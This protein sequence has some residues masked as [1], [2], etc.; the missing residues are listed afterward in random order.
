MAASLNSYLTTIVASVVDNND[1]TASLRSNSSSKDQL[2][3]G[4]ITTPGL[5]ANLISQLFWGVVVIKLICSSSFLK[6]SQ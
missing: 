4:K 2:S 3:A 6:V 1:N 5:S